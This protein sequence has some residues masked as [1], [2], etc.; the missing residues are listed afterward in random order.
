MNT[1]PGQVVPEHA[2]GS[3]TQAYPTGDSAD[4]E[5]RLD[6]DGTRFGGAAVAEHAFDPSRNRRRAR[7]CD[8]S[9]RRVRPTRRRSGVPRRPGSPA[10]RGRRARRQAPTGPWETGGRCYSGRSSMC[11][12]AAATCT[13]KRS[14]HPSTTAPVWTPSPGRPRQDRSRT[15]PTAA[16]DGRARPAV[17]AQIGLVYLR[18]GR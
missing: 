11:T 5:R 14:A 9:G 10:C 12:A 7:A 2:F 13:S 1:C 8:M 4:N 6:R 16:P 15:S 18:M 17:R 3:R